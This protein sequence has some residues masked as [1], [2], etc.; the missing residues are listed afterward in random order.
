MVIGRLRIT[1]VSSVCRLLGGAEDQGHPS[2][3]S[4]IT[5]S[6]PFS[7]QTR[8]N[9]GAAQTETHFIPLVKQPAWF[10]R[11]RSISKEYDPDG[12]DQARYIS[13]NSQQDIE[14]EV[15]SQPDFQEDAQ[16]RD[17]NR[18]D[19]ATTVNHVP[20]EKSSRL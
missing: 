4:R 19:E 18:E 5:M 1:A 17:K 2:G 6:L 15:T 20:S 11:I 14:P 16:R 7:G 8:S 10:H 9:D 3:R 12:V 13:Q